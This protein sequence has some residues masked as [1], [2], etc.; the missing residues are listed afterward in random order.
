[1]LITL[2]TRVSQNYARLLGAKQQSGK[3]ALTSDPK[4]DRSQ[5]ISYKL[6]IQFSNS[7]MCTYGLKYNTGMYVTAW[8]GQFHQKKVPNHTQ[9]LSSDMSN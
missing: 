6:K 2:C 9:L 5:G 7:G 1:M 4:S 8:N 3:T